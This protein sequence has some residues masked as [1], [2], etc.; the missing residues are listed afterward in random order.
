MSAPVWRWR[1]YYSRLRDGGQF[2]FGGMRRR[3]RR[4]LL[5]N[6]GKP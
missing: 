3:P 2:I 6:G 5:S 4:Q 1:R